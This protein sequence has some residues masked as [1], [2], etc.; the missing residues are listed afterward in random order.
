MTS[1]FPAVPLPGTS[2]APMSRRSTISICSATYTL[3]DMVNLRAGVNN[4]FDKSP[5][6][7]PTGSGS[8]PSRSLHG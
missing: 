5:P 8:C 6:I 4:I 7:I 2:L 1:P 3:L